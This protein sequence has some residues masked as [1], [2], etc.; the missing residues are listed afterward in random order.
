MAVADRMHEP[1][2]YVC[3]FCALVRGTPTEAPL[4]S[5]VVAETTGALALVSPRRWPRSPGHVLVVSRAHHENLYSIPTEDLLA[6]T[7]LVQRTAIAV[8]A[9]LPCTGTSIRQ[10]NEPA[11]G[12]DVWHFHVHVFPRSDG[13]EL[14]TP[15]EG[16]TDPD[17]RARLA[18]R[19]REHPIWSS[20]PSE[21]ERA[22]SES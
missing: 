14:T 21:P 16:F 3:P 18:G 13:V 2:G 6:L 7:A 4:Q 22:S 19:L 20:A 9:T 1:P 8:R 15:L 17:E 5:D 10:H 11:G 12:Q